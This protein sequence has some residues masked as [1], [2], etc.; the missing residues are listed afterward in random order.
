MPWYKSGTVYVALN[1]NAVIGTGTAFL[2]NSRVGDAF[3]GPDGGWYEVTNIASDTAMSIAPNYQGPTSAGGSYALAP[4]Q[5]YVKDSADALRGLV[6]TYGAKLAA[7][8]TTGNYDILP[9]EKGGT[10]GGS[11]ADARTGLG[12]G[13][14][15]TLAVQESASDKTAGRVLAV[16]AFGWNGGLAISQL[17]TADVRALPAG[18]FYSFPNGGLNLP[19]PNQAWYVEVSAHSTLILLEATGMNG[20]NKGQRFIQ[21][22][23]GVSWSGWTRIAAAGAN[24]DITSLTGLT[25]ALSVTQGGTGVTSLGALAIALLAAGVYGKSNILG[26]V[27]QS[28]GVPTGAVIERG[29]NANGEWTKYADGTM[30]CRGFKDL[31]SQAI[32]TPVG[33]LFYVGPFNGI[34]FP[35]TYVGLVETHVDIIS[36]GGLAWATQGSALPTT[37]ATGS[38]FIL[39]PA[40]ATFALSAMWTAIG[41]WYA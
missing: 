30:I 18:Y 11:Q 15:A 27:S 7:L 5:G 31:G 13:S 1:S 19:V 37:T 3:R 34:V 2:S 25:T 8:G 4:M 21:V 17:N 38:F 20:A 41:R 23:D 35:Q 16:G 29:S 28:A 33:S 14:V 39:N 40:S 9:I 10:G 26:S 22:Y 12:L 24:S 6:N 36:S 32:I